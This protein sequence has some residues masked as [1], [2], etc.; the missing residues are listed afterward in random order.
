MAADAIPKTSGD[1]V[2]ANWM[3]TLPRRIREL[4]LIS[5]AIPG[6][7]NTMMYQVL[8]DSPAAPD[9]PRGL[10]TLN[11]LFPACVQSWIVTQTYTVRQQLEH[12]IRYLDIRTSFRKGQFMFC[13]GLYACDSLQPLEE[14]NRFLEA[15]PKEVVILDFQHVYQCDRTLH[16]KYCDT[17]ISI[18]GRKILPRKETD[19]RQ[20]SLK[21]MADAGQQVIVI[22][23]MYCDEET[24][25]WCSYHFPTPWPNTMSGSRLKQTLGGNIQLR[26]RENGHVTQCV[27]TPTLQYI[28]LQ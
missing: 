3:T 10:Q 17:I 23:R 24:K 15:H 25:F 11:R 8:K 19:L 28:I 20:C 18:F 2:L 14:V 6:S 12:G 7:H 9:A 5:I 21:S 26:D 16:Q 1:Q 13:H 22:Y 4:P 27:M